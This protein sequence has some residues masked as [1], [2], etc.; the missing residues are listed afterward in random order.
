MW[1]PL[2]KHHVCSQLA[3]PHVVLPQNPFHLFSSLQPTSSPKTYT[4]P[5]LPPLSLHAAL[6]S[7]ITHRRVPHAHYD[8]LSR[9]PPTCSNGANLLHRDPAVPIKT[10]GKDHQFEETSPLY[11]DQNKHAKRV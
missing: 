10:A 2:T 8:P 6:I 7:T 11:I 4:K 5:S 9:S 1:D 3:Y